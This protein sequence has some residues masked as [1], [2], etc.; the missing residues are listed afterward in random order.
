[1]EE[2][3]FGFVVPFPRSLST[4]AFSFFFLGFERFV[5]DLFTH[6]T[7]GIRRGASTIGTIASITIRRTNTI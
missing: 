3:L 2:V 4:V 5:F 6:D 7:I 1:V